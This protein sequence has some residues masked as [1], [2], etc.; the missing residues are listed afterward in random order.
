MAESLSTLL[1]LAERERD[2]ARAALMRAEDQSNHALAQLEQLRAY[3]A[4]YRTRTPG[5]GGAAAPIA[6]LR[7]HLGFM[8]RLDQA[9]VQQQ[10]AVSQ[11]EA[12]LHRRRGQLQQAE[13]RLASVRKLAERRDAELRRLDDHR[14]Q[15][16]SDEAAMQRHRHRT[17]FGTLH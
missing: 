1:Q 11:C 15:R 17:G 8:G 16:R 3:Q 10:A 12:E 6:V 13:V 14:E 7:M 4:D 2:A 9:L 5:Q